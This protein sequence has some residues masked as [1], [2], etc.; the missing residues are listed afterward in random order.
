MMKE[1]AIQSAVVLGE[2]IQNIFVATADAEGLPHVAAAGRISSTS[3]G[4]V[5]VSAWFCPG[6][7]MN[8][9]KNRRVALVVWDAAADI[10]YQILGVVEK[11][12]DQAMLDGYSAEMEES[13]QPPQVERQLLVHVE[14]V[15]H[16]S[17]APHN[18]AE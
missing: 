17:H 4:Y 1:E 9:Q 12:E 10:G 18:D 13:T 16:F 14:K 11:V 8:I 7:V 5:A 2:K 6:T 15:I 3:A